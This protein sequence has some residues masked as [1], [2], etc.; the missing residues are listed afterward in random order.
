M[1]VPGGSAAKS[2]YGAPMVLAGAA[3]LAVSGCA[4]GGDNDAVATTAPPSTTVSAPVTTS[5]VAALDVEALRKAG[6]TA[7]AAVAGST[8]VSIETERDHGWEVQVVTADG[9]EHEME[10]SGDGATVTMGPVAKNEDDA[11]K[12]KH[13][14]RIRAARVDYRAAADSV[15]REVP[16]GTITELNL[17]SDN[18]TTVWESDVIDPSGTKHEVTVDA[19]SGR[20]MSNTTER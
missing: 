14:D 13:R 1:R 19:V 6:G 5:A 16:G 20:V 8:L 11:D 10:V 2:R 18:G 12:A 4:D 7:T 9:V 17:D 3:L 15:L